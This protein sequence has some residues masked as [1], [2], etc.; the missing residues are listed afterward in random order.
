MSSSSKP[1]LPD[2]SGASF[3]NALPGTA[4]T[5]GSFAPDSGLSADAR[6]ARLRVDS[7]KDEQLQLDFDQPAGRRSDDWDLVRDVEP[8]LPAP[9]RPAHPKLS[10]D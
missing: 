10:W 9:I 1:G 3:A 2:A 6:R 8:P 7:G 4:N 5:A